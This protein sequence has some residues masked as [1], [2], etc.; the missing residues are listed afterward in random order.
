MKPL[1]PVTWWQ[2]ALVLVVSASASTS[3]WFVGLVT[4]G[5][6]VVI[7]IL[8]IGRGELR[9]LWLYSL[10]AVFAIAVRTVFGAI[11]GGSLEFSILLGLRIAAIIAA[12]GMANLAAN[13]RALLKSAPAALYE[14]S[15]AFAMAINFGPQITASAERIR[16]ARALRGG[17]KRRMTLPTMLI[18]VLQ[19]SLEKS[20]ALATSM[21]ARGF[22]AGAAHTPRAK[23][24][25]RGCLLSSA[26]LVGAAAGLMLAAQTVWA[27][28]AFFAAIALAYVAIRKAGAGSRR[29][30]YRTLQRSWI[31]YLVPALALA[32]ASTSFLGW[33]AF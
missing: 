5:S 14:V 28:S 15:L 3:P 25:I 16:R 9:A 18:A 10:L 26:I 11:F 27:F 29:T 12:V 17:A 30:T 8:S 1:H 23:L 31:D 22:G 2:V 20:V 13:P 32:L 4:F 33:W 19:D 7:A 21:E 6:I 24:V